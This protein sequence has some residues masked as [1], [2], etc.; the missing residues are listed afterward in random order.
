MT[1]SLKLTTTVV[2]PP[3]DRDVV[4]KLRLNGQF[5]IGTARFTDLDIQ[6][7]VN[8]LSH[9]SR[10]E[11]SEAGQQ[12]VVSNFKGRFTLGEGTL[13]LPSLTFDTLGAAVHLT[14][15]YQLRPEM[16]DFK[17][18]LLMDAKISETQTGFTRVVLKAIDPLFTKE[19]GGAAIPIKIEGQREN[20]SFGLD[21]SRVFKRGR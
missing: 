7:K 15:S 18:T 20:P 21:R 3:G 2:L 8:E 12:N 1:G 5:V 19:G 16:L 4:D 10:G 17:G 9:R 6:A 13:A 14:G 11:S